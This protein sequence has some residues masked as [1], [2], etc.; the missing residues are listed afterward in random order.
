MTTALVNGRILLAEGFVA[1]RAV[2][3]EGDRIT[4]LLGRDDPRMAG[5]GS[6]ISKAETRAIPVTAR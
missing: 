5:S 3:I 6:M 4:A 1:D 2:V